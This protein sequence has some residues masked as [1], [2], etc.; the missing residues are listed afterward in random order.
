VNW[1]KQEAVLLQGVVQAG[2][3]FAVSFGLHLNPAQLSATLALSAAVLALITRQVI[4]GG[5]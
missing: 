5:Q 2:L 4:K 3:C 1:L